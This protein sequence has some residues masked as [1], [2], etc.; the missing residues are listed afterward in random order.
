MKQ[1]TLRSSGQR[2]QLNRQTRDEVTVW[3]N[4]SEWTNT[5]SNGTPVS[6]SWTI[7]APKTTEPI[8]GPPVQTGQPVESVFVA[9]AQEPAGIGSAQRGEV[10]GT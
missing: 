2:H 9:A 1:P 4:F 7:L 5:P 3:T 10:S 8:L 6:K